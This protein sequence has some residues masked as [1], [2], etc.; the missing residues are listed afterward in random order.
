MNKENV[1][2]HL[3]SDY[4]KNIFSEVITNDHSYLSRAIKLKTK[5]Q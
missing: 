5:I 1:I 4:E 3:E 2:K